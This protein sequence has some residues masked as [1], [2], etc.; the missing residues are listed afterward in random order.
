MTAVS[1]VLPVYNEADN[2][3]PLTKELVPVLDSAGYDYE[4]FFVDD[5]S[6]DDSR[7]S[8]HHLA[9]LFAPV[10]GVFLRRNFGQSAA[11]A[12]G[13]DHANGE[14]IVTLDA[15]GQNDPAD[16]PRLLD[17]LEAGYDC[18]SGW[19]KERNDPVAKR[20]PSRI[21]TYLARFTGP[22]IHDF[23]C[24]LT[25]YRA[26][27]LHDITVYGEGHRYIP[28]KLYKHGY[29]ITE[30][31]VNHRER[32]HGDSKYG[33]GRLVRGL[34]DLGF[35]IFWNRYSSRPAHVL[36]GGGLMLILLGALIGGHAIVLKYLFGI[37][38]VP[39]LPRLVLTAL[40]VLLGTQLVVFGLLAEMH[41]KRFYRNEREYRVSA[42]VGFDVDE[43]TAEVRV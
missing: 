22:D 21:Q 16:I 18:V 30:E 37:S 5:G 19:R 36:G 20:I 35:H 10:R 39:R 14:Y 4:I 12:A 24:T 34:V 38:L 23:G 31:E 7:E 1:V 27:A 6:T 29:R 40:F 8:I 11:I 9:E 2:L 15:D 3:T 26:A 41:T 33:A 13:I 28:A 42:A 32:K 25:A 43:P 17:R